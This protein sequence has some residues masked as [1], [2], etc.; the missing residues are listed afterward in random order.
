MKC[1]VKTLNVSLSVTRHHQPPQHS[2]TE[3]QLSVQPYASNSGI[4]QTPCGNSWGKPATL[5]PV[6]GGVWDK[7]QGWAVIGPSPSPPLCV[8]ALVNW[9]PSNDRVETVKMLLFTTRYL[10]L[11]Q[12]NLSVIKL[13]FMWLLTHSVDLDYVLLDL[14]GTN[15]Q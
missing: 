2:N 4:K 10:E 13:K 6:R 11:E 14:W 5:L 15:S 7:G 1:H 8:S 12:C 3:H 9:N